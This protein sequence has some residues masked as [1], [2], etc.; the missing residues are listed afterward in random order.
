MKTQ[1]HLLRVLGVGFGLAVIIGNTIGAG[2][3][4]APGSIAE[5][6]PAPTLSCSSGLPQAF[7]HSSARSQSPSSARCCRA[8]AGSTC[9]PVMRSV[10]M[11]G[12]SSAGATGSHRAVR[13]LRC[14]SSSAHLPCALSCTRRKS[15]GDRGRSCDRLRVVAVARNCL[16]QQHSKHHEPA[17]SAR[18]SCVD[19]CGV[20]LR[21]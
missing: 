21:R 14:R 5:Q 3:F 1:G 15:R 20:H 2:I 10:N 12:S 6:L 9:F 11:R 13:P 16:G 17:E 8:R 4:R 18:V 7:T 19:R